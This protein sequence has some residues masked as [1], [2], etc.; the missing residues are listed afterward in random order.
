MRRAQQG[1][2][3]YFE[4]PAAEPVPEPRPPDDHGPA[5]GREEQAAALAR[6]RRE[7]AEAGRRPVHTAGLHTAA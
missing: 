2:P 6:A 5:L 1:A 4:L 7:L 3:E